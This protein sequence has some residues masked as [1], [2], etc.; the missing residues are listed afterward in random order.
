[1]LRPRGH[2]HRDVQEWGFP[3]PMTKTKVRARA[4]LECGDLA[5][6]FRAKEVPGGKQFR[7]TPCI[8][9]GGSRFC[10]AK[11]QDISWSPQ[12]SAELWSLCHWI[13][14]QD[15]MEDADWTNNVSQWLCHLDVVVRSSHGT[16]RYSHPSIHD[17]TLR[18]YILAF[19]TL[20]WASHSIRLWAPWT[21]SYTS[22][23]PQCLN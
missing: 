23:F 12:Q 4:K 6:I 20:R 16:Y 19:T 8:R 3:K 5:E 21:G 14:H 7:D 15:N 1:M 10:G 11:V 22:P 18:C 13:C 2:F 9:V 17:T